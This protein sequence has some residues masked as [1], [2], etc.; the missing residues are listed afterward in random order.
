MEL[1][2]RKVG[3]TKTKDPIIERIRAYV[4]VEGEEE[5]QDYQLQMRFN[6]LTLKSLKNKG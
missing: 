1:T 5:N 4:L 6:D 3:V 2:K